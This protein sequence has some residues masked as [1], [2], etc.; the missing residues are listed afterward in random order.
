MDGGT[1]L[2]LT[3]T[4]GAG[5]HAVT[6][7]FS[8]DANYLASTTSSGVSITVASTDFTIAS[9]GASSQ[10]VIPGGTANFTYVL[11]PTS[12]AYPGPVTFTVSGLP[13]GA[14]Y[15][16]SPNTVASNAGP[17]QVKL[18][19]Q[20]PSSTAGIS[21]Q[22]RGWVLAILLLPFAGARRLRSTS[23]KMAGTLYILLAVCFCI[24]M[25]GCGSGNGFLIQSARDYA[26]TITASSGTISHTSTVNLNVQ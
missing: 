25:T 7:T 23:K 20:A 14:T 15:T 18:T 21:M 10:T 22:N 16:L 1:D 8:G 9:T 19:I 17:Q 11:T 4:L 13:T 5:A 6:A 12:G 3:T 24:G 26:V 2:R